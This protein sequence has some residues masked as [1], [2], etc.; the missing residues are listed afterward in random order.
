MANDG[1]IGYDNGIPWPRLAEDLKHFRRTTENGV[2]IMGRKTYKSIGK[3]LPN[4]M[5]LV[6]TTCLNTY[7]DKELYAGGFQY[8]QDYVKYHKPDEV[9]VIGGSEIFNLFSGKLS[10]YIV[11]RVD[12]NLPLDSDPEKV[13]RFPW[14]TGLWNR[15]EEYPLFAK[16][17]E[18]EPNSWLEIWEKE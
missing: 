10:K 12:W 18:D 14:P 16:A 7:I 1:V 2:V 17:N 9:F 3:P 13:V 15:T 6:V 11:T 5:N 4:R 8:I